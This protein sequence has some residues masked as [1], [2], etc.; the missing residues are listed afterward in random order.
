MREERSPA[1]S[2]RQGDAVR[3]LSAEADADRV[4]SKRKRMNNPQ[5]APGRRSTITWIVIYG[6]INVINSEKDN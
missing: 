3:R 1:T 6:M 4:A 5:T 2:L